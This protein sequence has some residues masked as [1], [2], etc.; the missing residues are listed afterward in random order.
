M[1]PVKHIYV[2]RAFERF[3]HW[4]QAILIMFLAVTGFEIHGSI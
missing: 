2:Y 4:G 1:S 3:W